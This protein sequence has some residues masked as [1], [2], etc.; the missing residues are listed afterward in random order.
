[1]QKLKVNFFI[2][3][4]RLYFLTR[5]T[6]IKIKQ[7]I[8]GSKKLA[9]SAPATPAPAP[10]PPTTTVAPPTVAVP[11]QV[12]ISAASRPASPAPALELDLRTIDLQDL[13][14]LHRYG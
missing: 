2:H 8:I 12:V 7:T 11:Q 6:E 13:F 4:L 3:L 1:M 9:S 10:P 14:D 5:S